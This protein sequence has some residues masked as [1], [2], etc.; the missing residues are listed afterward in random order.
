MQEI[1]AFNEKRA[2]IYWWLSS[3]YANELTEENLQQYQ[4]EQIRSFLSG[5][6]ENAELKPAIDRVIDALNRLMDREDA[7]LELAADFCELFLKSDRD[8][9]LPYAS[10]YIGDSGLLNDKP[11]KEMEELMKQHGV[12]VDAKLNE[13]ADHI[14]IELDLLGNLIVRS[15][16]LEQERH[17]EEAFAEQEKFIRQYIL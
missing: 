12:A 2:E 4:S 6:G 16:E 14:A 13:P 9:A 7:Q 3:L 10:M 17:L 5:L 1:K 8:S 15:N 11:A